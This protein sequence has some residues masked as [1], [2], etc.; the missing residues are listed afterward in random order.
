VS[1]Q[2]AS[3]VQQEE[4]LARFVFSSNHIRKE[5]GRVHENAF[6]PPPVGALSVT[7]HNALDSEHLWLLGLA[8]GAQTPRTL[9]GR[10]DVTAATY[11][12]VKLDVKAAPAP[13]ND[14]HAEVVGWPSE[15]PKQKLIALEVAAQAAAVPYQ[16]P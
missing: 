6:M 15:K 11:R 9:Y 12:S 1:D 4:V 13:G 7:R 5:N 2:S 10:A 14:H 8:I 3:R 16:H